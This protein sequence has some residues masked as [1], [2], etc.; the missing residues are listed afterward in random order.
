[1]TIL[2]STAV[3]CSALLIAQNPYTF[4]QEAQFGSG[5]QSQTEKTYSPEQL[6]RFRFSETKVYRYVSEI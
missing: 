4:A 3:L 2:R 1:M 5:S 6:V